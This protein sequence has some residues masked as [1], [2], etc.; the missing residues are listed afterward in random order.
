M[1]VASALPWWLRPA[2]L[3][4]PLGGRYPSNGTLPCSVGGRYPSGESYVAGQR[5]VDI[6]IDDDDDRGGGD[7]G[8]ESSEAALEASQP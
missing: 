6:S 7:G 4:S 5:F 3:G 8:S 2:P 1:I